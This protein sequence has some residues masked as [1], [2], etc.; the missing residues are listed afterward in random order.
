MYGR[1]VEGGRVE[2]GGRGRERERE[3]ERESERLNVS[4]VNHF[5]E[6]LL[7][8]CVMNPVHILVA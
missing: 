1:G 2:R 3:R 5:V 7:H 6:K 8:N 4:L